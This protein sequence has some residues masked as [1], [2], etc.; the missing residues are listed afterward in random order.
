MRD[1]LTFEAAPFM[2]Y[3]EFDELESAEQEAFAE[4]VAYEWEGEVSRSNAEYVRWV[5]QSL[6]KILNLAL[7]ADGISGPLTRSAVRSF[8]QRARLVVDGI[9]GP[10]T[11]AALVAAGAA[12]PPGGGGIA[13]P[14]GGSGGGGVG[15]G[16]GANPCASL[17]QPCEVLQKF[18]FDKERVT[19]TH[20]SQINNIAGCVLESHKTSQPI[21]VV[22]L[23][24]HTDAEGTQSYNLDLGRRRAERVK[25]HLRDAFESIKRGSSSGVTLGVETRG[26]TQPVSGV[27]AAN[28]RVEVCLPKPSAPTPPKPKPVTQNFKIVVKSFINVIGFRGA[29]STPCGIGPVDL[30]L[31]ALARVTDLSMSENPP[32]DIRNKIYRLFSSRTFTVSCLDGRIISFTGTPLDTDV[33]LECDPT[34]TA[35]LTPPPLITVSNSAGP[36]GVSS[37]DFTWRVKGRPN[38]AAEPAFQLV[39]PRIS[40]FIWHEVSGR[41]ECTP[42]GLSLTRL[43]IVGSRFPSHR[44]WV[45]GVAGGFIPQRDYSN[46]WTPSSVSDPTLVR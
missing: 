5:Q 14:K 20:Q 12:R 7:A 11:E 17:R 34:R 16:G 32:T 3:M 46:L 8:Q 28:R 45:N 27:A 36:S 1:E 24:G 38:L 26:E 44:V 25:Q 40:V 2:G 9:V 43:T 39:C 29:G 22:R 30:K 41:I 18:D 21:R 6:N 15:V 42:S 4:G 10:K 35:C 13:P 23:I 31:A 37:I 19:P 33:G